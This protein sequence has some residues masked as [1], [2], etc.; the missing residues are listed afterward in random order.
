MWVRVFLEK[1]TLADW[2][3]K[4]TDYY[5]ISHS[6]ESKMRVPHA[7]AYGGLLFVHVAPFANQLT[8]YGGG[9]NIAAGCTLCHL[10]PYTVGSYFVPAEIMDKE[11]WAVL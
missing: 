4:V 2:L 10:R 8:I 1:S 11:V 6:R 7:H 5:T 9:S 3:A